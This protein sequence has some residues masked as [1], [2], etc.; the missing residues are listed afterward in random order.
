VSKDVTVVAVEYNYHSNFLNECR[1]VTNANKRIDSAK[2]AYIEYSSLGA[3]QNVASG[4]INHVMANSF[5]VLRL[6]QQ[7]RFD[8]YARDCACSQPPA[9]FGDTL[10]EGLIENFIAAEAA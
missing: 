2:S 7:V 10:V 6:E 9:P 5:V 3:K 8:S 1:A 4:E